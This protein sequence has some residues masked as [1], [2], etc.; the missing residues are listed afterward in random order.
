MVQTLNGFGLVG[1][2]TL[3]RVLR[4]ELLELT[5]LGGL[6]SYFQTQVFP[7]VSS[8]LVFVY[9]YSCLTQE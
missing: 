1:G 2:R 7:G 4:T 6:P 8:K 3:R 9:L 5:L